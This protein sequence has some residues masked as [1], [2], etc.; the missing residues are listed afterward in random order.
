V[1]AFP[2]VSPLKSGVHPEGIKSRLK[3]ENAWCR[4]VQNFLTF[5][6][7]S[8]TERLKYT[9]YDKL[10]VSYGCENWS[11]ILRKKYR[12]RLFENMAL[13]KIVGHRRAGNK[14]RL[15]KST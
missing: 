13:R 15:E 6:L 10:V 3:S 8:K 2:R 5:N 9:L 14:R 7:V 4:S 11:L 12:L 1:V